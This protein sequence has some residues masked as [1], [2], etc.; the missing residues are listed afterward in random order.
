[1]KV[2]ARIKDP[3]VIQKILNHLQERAEYQDTSRLP[4]SR[5][6]PQTRLFG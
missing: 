6:R 3:G 2:I 1:M 5:G 4:E